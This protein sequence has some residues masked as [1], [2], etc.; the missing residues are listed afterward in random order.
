MPAA[1]ADDVPYLKVEKENS[2]TLLGE[3]TEMDQH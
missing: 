1:E 3:P 2:K